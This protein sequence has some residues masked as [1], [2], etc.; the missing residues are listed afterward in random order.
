MKTLSDILNARYGVTIHNAP[1]YAIVWAAEQIEDTAQAK[2]E[3]K[4]ANRMREIFGRP[5]MY[6]EFGSRLF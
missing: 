4:K 3:L 2:K 1:A 5:C 6:P